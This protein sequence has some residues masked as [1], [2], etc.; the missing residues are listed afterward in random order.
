MLDNPPPWVRNMYCCCLAKEENNNNNSAF[1]VCTHDVT[2]HTNEDDVGHFG[3]LRAIFAM[4]ITV[5]GLCFD[6][7]RGIISD[8][9]ARMFSSEIRA[10]GK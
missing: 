5:G 3:A 9:Q 1:R 10:F 8:I 6:I 4:M 2:N 7:A